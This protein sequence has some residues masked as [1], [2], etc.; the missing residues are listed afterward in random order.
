MVPTFTLPYNFTDFQKMDSD[1][2]NG[3]SQQWSVQ[4]DY[5][6][7]TPNSKRKLSMEGEIYNQSNSEVER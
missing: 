4:N 6:I 5:N 2:F 3:S 1:N 7:N